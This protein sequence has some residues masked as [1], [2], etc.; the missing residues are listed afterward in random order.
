MYYGKFTQRKILN[1]L[2]IFVILFFSLILTENIYSETVENK[3]VI[4]SVTEKSAPVNIFAGVEMV[5]ITGNSITSFWISR[6]EVTQELYKSIMETNP[7]YFKGGRLPVEQVSW[8][9]AVEFC[10]RLSIKA[11]F[12][13]YYNIEKKKD[14]TENRNG[15]NNWSVTVN[16]EADG[17]R[18]PLSAEWEYAARAGRSDKYFWGNRM[19]GDYCWYSVNSNGTTH[20]VGT[21]KP[22][23]F[24]IFDIIGN[25][26]EWCFDLESGS[27]GIN[28]MVRDGHYSLSAEE[29]QL[30]KTDFRDPNLEFGFTGIRLVKNK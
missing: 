20:P 18:L 17:F 6:F 7:G 19:N 26:G 21:K 23:L 14:N 29:M 16:S 8:Y 10:N 24:G 13:T 11:G 28:R 27:S 15:G 22:N 4:M 5:L 2:Q 3:N 1:N 30:D 9:N 25:V 12:H